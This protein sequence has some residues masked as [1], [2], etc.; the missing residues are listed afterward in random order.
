MDTNYHIHITS[1]PKGLSLNL[2]E[3]WDYRDL[4]VLFTKRS[5]ALTFKQTVLGPAWI[6]LNPLITSIIHTLVFGE[7]AG[8][9][10]DGIPKI[11]FYFT[12]TALWNY[13]A[14]CIT[15]NATTF[16]SNAAVFGKVYFP[17]LSIPISNM[18]S[19]LI[20]FAIQMLLVGAFLVFFLLRG[21]V[22]PH[23]AYWPVLPF[24]LLQ[25]GMMG[26]GVG[27][28]VSSLT[29]KY[30]DLSILVGFGVQLWMYATPIVYSLSIVGPSL[31]RNIMLIN[32]VT[33]PVEVFRYAFLGQGT[34]VAGYLIWS[35]VF[36]FAVMILGILI[37]N[38][39]EKT[40]MDTV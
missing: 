27:I 16:T 22:H 32:P 7:I 35:I 24:V 12:S 28:I 2:R 1:K 29:T 15:Q 5:F 26:L 36:T 25:L 9:G 33:L 3:V 18:I 4:I 17:R 19:A 37:F 6:F 14:N 30:R 34:I 23:W 10:T 40:F 8:F 31:T 20:R 38:R 21:E 39:V 13:Y 11:L